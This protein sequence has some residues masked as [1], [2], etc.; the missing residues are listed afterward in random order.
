MKR[1]H[2]HIRVEDLD[3]SIAF[4]STVFGAAPDIVEPDYAKWLLDEPAANI[5]ISSHA[6]ETPGIDHV[7]VQTD[8]RE[9]LDEI[10]AR[11]KAA[12]EATFDQEATT[13]CYAV[14]DKTWVEDPSGVRWET[15]F[16]T[17]QSAVYGVD[18]SR[19]GLETGKAPAPP[20]TCC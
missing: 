20:R 9:A 14:G 6:G 19:K 2:M 8:S 3:R 17:G 5:A 7:G 4:Y 13:C 12:G 15:F 10:S 1:L 16:T 11:L 18:A